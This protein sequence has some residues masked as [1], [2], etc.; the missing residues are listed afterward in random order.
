MNIYIFI[1]IIL[2][3]LYININYNRENYVSNLVPIK[4][5]SAHFC[6]KPLDIITDNDTRTNIGNF[7]KT[8]PTS[9]YFDKISTLIIPDKTMI[10]KKVDHISGL[11]KHNTRPLWFTLR[12]RFR[13]EI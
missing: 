7:C 10:N 12:G 9:T 4:S 6:D 3:L 8:H 1:V 11:F 13:C 5:I 2:I